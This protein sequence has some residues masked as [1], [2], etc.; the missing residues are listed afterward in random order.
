[1]EPLT[2][3]SVVFGG[4]PAPMAVLTAFMG[5]VGFVATLLGFA[6]LRRAGDGGG[7]R[8]Y[9]AMARV[10]ARDGVVTARER[11]VLASAARGLH[12]APALVAAIERDVFDGRVVFS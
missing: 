10:A 3:E 9:R 6:L 1:M 8:A 5:V 11:A 2:L 12:L 4:T 7:A